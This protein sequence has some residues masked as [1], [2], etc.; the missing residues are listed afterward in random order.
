MPHTAHDRAAH[1]L[2]TAN[3][4]PANISTDFQCPLGLT[5]ATHLQGPARRPA[6]DSS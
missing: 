4:P 2:L 6:S 5:S 1:Q 3:Y